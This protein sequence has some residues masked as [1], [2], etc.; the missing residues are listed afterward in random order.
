M[1]E[2]VAGIVTELTDLLPVRHP[3]VVFGHSF[4]ALL[5]Y[6]TARLLRT[7]WDAWPRAL[8]VA[9]CRP[10][11]EWVGAGRG[12]ADDEAELTA[13]LDARGLDPD[14]LDEDSRELMLEVLRRDVRLSL[15]FTEPDEPTVGCELQSWGGTA[16]TTV[17]PEH[18]EGW[19]T[20]AAAGFRVRMF[21]GGH[22]ANLAEPERSLALLRELACGEPADAKGGTR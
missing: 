17:L 8:V 7:R 1:D 19:R 13:L 4:G 6:L 15:S 10:P 18:V 9:A 16:D 20:Y 3:V 11:R 22:Y 12:L 5:G 2:A 14:D 21:D